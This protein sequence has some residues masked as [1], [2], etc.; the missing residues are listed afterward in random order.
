MQR[1]KIVANFQARFPVEVGVDGE[2]EIKVPNSLQHI[3]TAACQIR[4]EVSD[5][6]SI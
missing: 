4:R 2:A 3:L 6:F 5:P 1:A